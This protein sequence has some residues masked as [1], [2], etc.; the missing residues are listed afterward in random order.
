MEVHA[1]IR[2]LLLS[3]AMLV[4]P[5]LVHAIQLHW[6]SGADNIDFA[7]ATRCTLVITADPGA[8]SLPEEWHLPLDGR[9]LPAPRRS[10]RYSVR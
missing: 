3:F 1:M 5:T 6:S 10:L 9:T 2:R 4:M 8:T 7:V